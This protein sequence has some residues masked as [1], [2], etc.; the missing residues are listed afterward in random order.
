M[1][2]GFSGLS[3]SLSPKNN[4]AQ[5]LFP[6]PISVR[7]ISIVLNS[8]HPRFKELGEWNALGI[9][10]YELVNYPNKKG[11]HPIAY[12][13]NS[14]LKNYPL[15]N[16]ITSIFPLSDTMIGESN[17]S[18][19]M[20]YADVISLWNH[21]HHN[22]YPLESNSLSPSQQKDYTQIEAGSVRRVTDKSTEIFLG[23]T[24]KERSN[25]HPLLPFEG[26]YILEGRWANSIRFGSTVN[27]TPNNWSKKGENGDPITIIRNGQGIQTEEGWKPITENINND[28][29]SIYLT[30]TQ[31]IP[32][33]ASSTSYVSYKINPPT[34]PEEYDGKQIILNSGRLVFNSNTDHILFSSVKSINL[35]SKESVNIDAPKTII[36][37]NKVYLGNEDQATE[38]LLLGNATVKLFNEFFKSLKELVKVLKEA[39]TSPA[40]VGEPLSLPSIN[41]VAV[42]LDTMLDSV[43][44]QLTKITS[45]RNYTT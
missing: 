30:S 35:N 3:K 4:F 5:S 40:V 43:S 39:Q 10:E 8:S 44:E 41:L 15:I 42:S 1:D 34:S 13:K 45:E 20:Y 23:E 32:L 17:S 6:K 21:P 2:Y 26:D 29:S 11:E 19:K 37:S 16:E 33:K 25:I 18:L 24:F 7:V 22:G 12:P 31:N 28:D 36:Q 14:N 38:P 27:N 9:I